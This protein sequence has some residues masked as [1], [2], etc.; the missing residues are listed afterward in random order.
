MPHADK[1]NVNLQFLQRETRVSTQLASKQ[2]FQQG[3][4]QHLRFINFKYRNIALQYTVI[5]RFTVSGRVMSLVNALADV[6][7]SWNVLHG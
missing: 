4:C 3:R 6:H 5:P 2:A 1:I 7:G